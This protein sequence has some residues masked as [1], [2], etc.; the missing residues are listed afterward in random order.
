MTKF[1]KR[2][3][4]LPITHMVKQYNNRK[5]DI[6]SKISENIRD[7]YI[8]NPMQDATVS[9]GLSIKYLAGLEGITD[10]RDITEI[11]QKVTTKLPKIWKQDNLT[12]SQG[13]VIRYNSL[14]YS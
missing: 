6:A 14:E 7:H 3:S 11:F 8:K 1:L 2:I 10:P 12:F 13:Y 4:Y 9:E 5:S